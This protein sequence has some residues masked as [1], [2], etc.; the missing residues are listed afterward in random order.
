M[1]YRLAVVD[2]L[3]AGHGR[4]RSDLGAEEREF[5]AGL[6]ANGQRP[7]AV[8]IGCSDSRVIP[9][10]LTDSG[11]GQLFVVRNVANHVPGLAEPDRSVSAAIEYA[12]GELGVADI[13]VCGHD[14]C[15]GIKAALSD[16]A[17]LDP[18][19]DL[20]SWLADVRPAVAAA[21]ASGLDPD[22]CLARAVEDNVLHGLAT[23]SAGWIDPTTVD[24]SIR[25][26]G[27]V[28]DVGGATLRV[29]DPGQGRFVPATELAG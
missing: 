4:F 24:G 11:P 20:G 14:G 10:Q 19:S 1:P 27:W 26:H 9:E 18:D 8:F 22:A 15:G 16:L 3:L 13:I 21:R 12:V 17:G 23:L 6:A 25:L 29:Y 7:T 5:L 28:F 2:E